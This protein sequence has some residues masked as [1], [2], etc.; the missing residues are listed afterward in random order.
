MGTKSGDGQVVCEKE[1]CIFPVDLRSGEHRQL[2]Q[3]VWGQ[4]QS[5]IMHFGH[6]R[7]RLFWFIQKHWFCISCIFTLFLHCV[8][9]KVTP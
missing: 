6:N 3:R 9:I 1:V 2:S 7:L 5:I 4:P 8:L